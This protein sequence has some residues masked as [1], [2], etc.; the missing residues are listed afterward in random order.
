MAPRVASLRRGDVLVSY[1][2]SHFT[3]RVK[4]EYFLPH[5]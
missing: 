1:S 2:Y 4:K 5:Q 3:G